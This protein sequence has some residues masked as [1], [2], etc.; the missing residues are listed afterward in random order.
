MHSTWSQDRQNLMD[1]VK[2]LV[3]KEEIPQARLVEFQRANPIPSDGQLQDLTAAEAEDF[4]DNWN[5]SL[6][7]WVGTQLAD[8]GQRFASTESLLSVQGSDKESEQG[9]SQS[10]QSSSNSGSGTGL[11]THVAV[12]A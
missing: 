2:E 8:D 6:S 3:A 12:E 7:T 9:S 1:R 5:E 11:S 4:Q 10:E